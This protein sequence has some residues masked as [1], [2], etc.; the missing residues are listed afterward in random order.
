MF[1]YSP[2]TRGCP[3]A[4][5]RLAYEN[6]LEQPLTTRRIPPYN[7]VRVPN[8]IVFL[9]S[10]LFNPASTNMKF[11]S[12]FAREETKLV[13]ALGASEM[14]IKDLLP[15]APDEAEVD[16]DKG[17]EDEKPEPAKPRIKHELIEKCLFRMAQAYCDLEN[18]MDEYPQYAT[19]GGIDPLS[20]DDE[21]SNKSSN[22]NNTDSG[23]DNEGTKF[24]NGLTALREYHDNMK[25]V[26][27]DLQDAFKEFADLLQL[28]N[29]D[30]CR[31]LLLSR[32]CSEIQAIDGRPNASLIQGYLQLAAKAAQSPRIIYKTP[33]KL[34]HLDK[35]VESMGVEW[36]E[37]YMI[38]AS[39]KQID[40]EKIEKGICSVQFK[41]V[42]NRVVSL[43]DVLDAM[44]EGDENN[45][46]NVY[47]AQ[48]NWLKKGWTSNI[49]HLRKTGK[50][51]DD[52][53]YL[54]WIEKETLYPALL[55]LVEEDYSD[56]D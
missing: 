1:I 46:L 7:D 37:S 44:E 48:L 52:I 3:K 35:I 27:K 10:M 36:E 38:A 16:D 47:H 14:Y 50:T 45:V 4:G 25:E 40:A 8:N 30:S 6:Q 43:S 56:Q 41:R 51:L 53:K 5:V 54:I 33:L 34:K 42:G 24:N 9:A 21:N 55:D 49:E 19:I 11:P 20:S 22:G 29:A 23:S 2:S 28:K 39:E 13:T 26:Y 32:K 18:A 17:D 15:I 31:S 12:S